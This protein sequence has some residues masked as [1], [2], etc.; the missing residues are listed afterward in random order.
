MSVTEEKAVLKEKKLGQLKMQ[1]LQTFVCT[2]IIVNTQQGGKA[3]IEKIIYSLI[4]Y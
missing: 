1:G 4:T 2:N 3:K